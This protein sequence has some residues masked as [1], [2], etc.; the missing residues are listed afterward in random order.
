MTSGNEKTDADAENNPRADSENV[1][2]AVEEQ[3]D[4]DDDGDVKYNRVPPAAVSVF[5]LFFTEIL[6]FPRE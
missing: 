5:L 3:A 1:D 6:L 4:G 2:L